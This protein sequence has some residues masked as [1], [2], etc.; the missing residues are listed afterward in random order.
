[1]KQTVLKKQAGLITG[2]RQPNSFC[3]CLAE[4]MPLLTDVPMSYTELMGYTGCAFHL[5]I[6]TAGINKWGPTMYDW[7]GLHA[8]G[9]TNIGISFKIVGNCGPHPEKSQFRIDADNLA[10]Q[11][12]N[13]GIPA[14]VWEVLGPEFGLIYGYDDETESFAVADAHGE[15]NMAYD[16]MG[17]EPEAGKESDIINV[18]TVERVV[19]ADRRKA[20]KGALESAVKYGFEIFSGAVGEFVYGLS[21]YDYWI[22]VFERSEIDPYGN[23]YTIHTLLDAREQATRFL[24]QAAQATALSEQSRNKLLDAAL[25]YSC[26]ADSLYK[27]QAIFPFPQSDYSI[28]KDDSGLAILL[29]KEIKKHEKQGLLTISEAIKLI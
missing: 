20:L 6:T 28:G 5:N 18:T 1:M 25:Q 15:G 11:S 8:Q 2:Y 9:M 26:V 27:L 24:R 4:V 19:V 23:A 17:I 13:N 14:I 16:T 10:K 3:N 29:L 22:G 12:V 21:A 7:D